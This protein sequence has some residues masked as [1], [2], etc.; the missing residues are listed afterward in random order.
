[1]R[2]L[3]DSAPPDNA[4]LV[5]AQREGNRRLVHALNRA[6]RTKGL[7]TGMSVSQAQAMLPGLTVLDAALEA[8]TAGLEALAI[9]ALQHFSPIAASEPPDGIVIDATGAA[10]LHGGEAAMLAAMLARLNKAGIT[11]RAAIADS[12]GA[13]HAFARFGDFQPGQASLIIAQGESATQ[14]KALPLAALRLPTEM[15]DSLHRLGFEQIGD[16][17][18]QPRA[19]L[20][21][22]FGP[23]LHIRLDRALGTLPEMIEPVRLPELIEVRRHFA[24]PISAAE[25]LAR[26]TRI[27]TVEL[28]AILEAR[29]LGARKL[30]L[31]FQRVDNEAQAIRIGTAMPVHDAKRLTRLLCAKLETIDPGFGIDVMSLRVPIAE[32]FARTQL[33][34][35]LQEDGLADISDLIDTLANRVGAQNIYRLAPVESDVPERSTKR[36]PALAPSSARVWQH[37]WPRPPRLLERPEPI[38]IVALLPDHP[39]VAFTWK[40]QRRKIKRADGPERIFGEWWKRR[41]ETA[42]V[43]DYFQVEDEAGE[44]FWIYRAGDGED[45]A[46]G[47]HYWFLHGFFG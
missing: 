15:V 16:L 5:L 33:S 26:Y 42:A 41:G 34:S 43:R 6:A 47:S 30:D 11:A 32:P 21:R 23:E 46:I 25:T 31:I 22:R 14:V 1:M 45:P 12:R 2:S 39:P 18:A 28:C 29:T 36:I 24:E 13:A 10:H 40:G 35:L 17:A 27:L 20:A 19:P 4:P 37:K 38:E 8:D 3:G 44:R 9:W 7:R